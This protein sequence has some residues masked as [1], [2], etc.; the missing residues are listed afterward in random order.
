MALSICGVQLVTGD[1]KDPFPA[2]AQDIELHFPARGLV[3]LLHLLNG[4][5][6]GADVECQAVGG[7]GNAEIF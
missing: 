7:I 1:Q 2:S 3:L 6:V 4:I 5:T